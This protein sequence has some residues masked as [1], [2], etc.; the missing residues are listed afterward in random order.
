MARNTPI[1]RAGALIL[2]PSNGG[3]HREIPAESDAWFTWLESARTFAFE[4]PSGRFTARK[5]RRWGVDYWYAFR[6]RSGRLYETYLGKAR[7]ITLGR[8]RAVATRLNQL[9]GRASGAQTELPADM[10]LEQTVD[11][12][13]TKSHP[14][15]TKLKAPQVRLPQLVRTAAV[16]RLALATERPLTLVSAPAGY[17]KTT[18]LTQWLATMH[19]PTTWLSLDE[20]DNDLV[21][22]WT[23]VSAALEQAIPSLLEG[24]RPPA[25]ARGMRSANDILTEL[26]AALAKA[27]SPTLLILDNYHE[28]TTDNSSIHDAVAYLVEHLPPQVHLVVASRT[29]PP[30]PLA[31]LRTRHHLLELD[32]GD[33][34]FTLTE[35]RVFLRRR[36][37][38]DLSDEEIAVLHERTEGW[39]TALQLAAL[40]LKEQS[41][42]RR[43]ITE[44]SGE[45]RH[46][47]DYLVEEVV[48]SMPPQWYTFALQTALLDRLSGPLCDAVTRLS[49]SQ[50]TLE[51]MERANLFLVPLDDRREWYRFHH[52]F[53]DVL[54]R[55]LRLIRPRLVP[56]LYARASAWC[57]THALA[58]EAIDYAFAANEV[59]ME[60]VAQLIEGYIPVALASGKI[61][62]LRDRL[63]RLPDK[64]VRERPRLCIAHAYTLFLSGERTV[65]LRRVHDAEEAVARS[66]HLYSASDLTILRSEILALRTIAPT[67]LGAGS[68]QMLIALFQR[69]LAAL[70]RNHAFRTFIT[71]YIGIHQMLDGDVH[72]ASRT[73]MGLMR[74]RES[75]GNSF[76]VGYII[77]YLGLVTLLQGRLDDTLELCGRAAQHLATSGD[78]DLEARIHLIRGK[79]FYERNEL[80]QAL[81]HLRHGMSLRYDPAAF[82]IEGFP[83]LAYVHLALGNRDA[84][85]QTIERSHTEWER[86][87][88]EHRTLWVWTRRQIRAHQARLWLLEGDV[89][90]ASAWAHELERISAAAPASKSAPPTYVREWEEIVLARAY[91]AERRTS[92]ALALLDALSETANAGKR[93]ARLLEILV[94]RAVAHDSLGDTSTALS[95]LQQAVELG[96]PQRFVRVFV[97]GGTTIGRLLLVLQANLTRPST[98]ARPRRDVR[99]Q[100]YLKS[101]ADAFASAEQHGGYSRRRHAPAAHGDERAAD[102]RATEPEQILTPR[103]QEVI[104]LIADG[105]SNNDIARMLVIAQS[106]AKRHVSNIFAKLKV[107]SRT[108]AVARARE[109]GFLTAE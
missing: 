57:E 1:I 51:E 49:N 25:P 86:A 14:S 9:G 60:R 47:F 103:E 7:D 81:D 34:Q 94:L 77:L 38:L 64:L 67:L 73:L 90:A 96:A 71:L 28:L 2:E 36:M 72:T 16:D 30:L 99:I 17:G 44:F 23:H 50:A 85:H 40:A 82:L 41:D 48:K 53:A 12:S 87:R 105:A 13:L 92:D 4:D 97:E 91:L 62:L 83:A 3:E 19:L 88:A 80:D 22:F 93:V 42:T 74:A 39:I 46:I 78:D 66:Q 43:W 69:A 10:Q 26:I 58:L 100:H 89:A 52:L 102:A 18:L 61:A 27:P 106:T 45:N 55:Y 21:R 54:R 79:V 8:L 76:Y 70:P 75:Q 24:V 20:R 65:L 5:K 109:L 68:P 95:V 101:I 63:E 37:K 104:R 98:S 59:E 108:Q 56:L 31:K 35:T 107:R 33:L 29:I 11:S 6:R 32:T 84:A 15:I